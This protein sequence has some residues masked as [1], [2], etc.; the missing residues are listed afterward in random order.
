VQVNTGGYGQC[1]S[2]CSFR[3]SCIGFSFIG[4]DSGTCYL[5]DSQSSSEDAAAS[6][7][8]WVTCYKTDP[9]LVPSRTPTPTST[10]GAG[11]S[12]GSN[13]GAIAGGAVGGIA[14]IAI[15]LALL[16]VFFRRHRRKVD[17]RHAK[18]A[19]DLSKPIPPQ[20]QYFDNFHQGTTQD[21]PA[22]IGTGHHR[23]GSTGWYHVPQ[24]QRTRQRSIYHDHDEDRNWV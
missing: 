3:A 4:E 23:T 14:C 13:V 21:T 24:A 19:R 17:E 12:G 8:T 15:I 22:P 5:R 2:I 6:V 11:G 20:E 9:G 1:F 16:A 18:E 10:P 7:S